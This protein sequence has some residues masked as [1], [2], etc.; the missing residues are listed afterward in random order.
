MSK[1]LFKTI[2]KETI[3]KWLKMLLQFLKKVR[4]SYKTAS[5]E[6]F[7]ENAYNIKRVEIFIFV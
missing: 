1:P 4:Q 2:I 5:Y 3:L 7:N 6:N